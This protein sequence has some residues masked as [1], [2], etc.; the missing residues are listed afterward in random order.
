M[1]ECG[2]LFSLSMEEPPPFLLA[3]LRSIDTLCMHRADGDP[4]GTRN[5]GTNHTGARRLKESIWPI[6]G[7]A[8]ASP[9]TVP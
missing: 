3:L 1:L 5:D 8:R 6:A 9:Q 2:S 7:T 4:R